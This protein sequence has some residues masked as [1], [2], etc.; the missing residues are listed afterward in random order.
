MCTSGSYVKVG[1]HSTKMSG[2]CVCVVFSL[3]VMS[4]VGL[5]LPT[6]LATRGEG[7]PQRVRR[8]GGVEK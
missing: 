5:G 6:P 2:V 7:C 8:V 1:E 3:K 4:G